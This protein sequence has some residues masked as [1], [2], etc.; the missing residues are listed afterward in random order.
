[1]KRPSIVLFLLLLLAAACQTARQTNRNAHPFNL[2][3]QS[4]FD[5]MVYLE[6]GT[7]TMGCTSE[8][9]SDC[10]DNESPARQVSVSSFSISKYLVTQRQWNEVMKT[11]LR[12]Q[13]DFTNPSLD[14]VGE[15]DDYPMYYVSWEEAQ[16]FIAN[17]NYLTSKN[18]RLP[19][20]AEWEYAARGGNKSN[21]YKY[22]G[23]DIEE[24]VAWMNINSSDRMHSVGV[25]R[26]NELGLYDMSGNVWEWCYDWFGSYRAS[27]QVN[28]AGPSAGA[29][30][31][32][33]GGS[34]NR[35]ARHCRVS[36]RHN[37]GPGFRYN[38]VG[39]R[40]VLSN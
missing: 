2:V 13:R 32:L 40:L 20:E 31:V 4:I 33:R 11:T 7:F 1:M 3:L 6:G 35:H 8:Q 34:W 39:F 37:Y 5:N 10:F 19:T 27:A 21:G 23:S 9:G 30:R 22:A 26:A 14:L 25:K 24:Q 17:L 18:Y 28:P 38:E 16:Q 15:G 36:S 12:Q 29:N